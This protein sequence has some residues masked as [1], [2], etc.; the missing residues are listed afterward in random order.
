MRVRNVW[1]IVGILAITAVPI[2]AHGW[3]PPPPPPPPPVGAGNQ[4]FNGP[5][6]TGSVDNGPA[7]LGGGEYNGPT[8]SGGSEA[9]AASEE[10]ARATNLGPAT[11]AARGGSVARPTK[12]KTM[13][14]PGQDLLRVA[15]VPSFLPTMANSGY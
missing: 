13:A 14:A 1:S 9:P 8:G 2:L 6:G 7:G 5:T 3:A 11:G 15:W 4:A 10:R 12:P